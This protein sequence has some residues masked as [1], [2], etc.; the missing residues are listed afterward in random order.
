MS[1]SVRPILDSIAKQGSWYGG[2]S[3]A[4]LTCAVSAALLE[5]LLRASSDVR[6]LRALRMRAMALIEQDAK[7][8][9]QV[10]H[11]YYRGSRSSAQ[12]KLKVAIE[13]PLTVYRDSVH[14]LAV[15]ARSRR[16]IKPRYRVD[17]D[18][19]V[20]LANATALASLA[21]VRTNLAWLDEPAF[22]RRV[23]AE[24]GRR[25]D[26]RARVAV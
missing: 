5:K 3:A 17:L 18:C 21:L 20:A 26:S 14:L 4:A 25:R 24:L 13:I 6:P 7:A 9:S 10:I 22:T 15:A 23:R 16:L 1:S 19:A 8:F 12:R 2:G 11:A